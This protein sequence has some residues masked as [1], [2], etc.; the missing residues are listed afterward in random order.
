MGNKVE[1]VFY[2]LFHLNIPQDKILLEKYLTE[3]SPDS[4]K[5]ERAQLFY[6]ALKEKISPKEDITFEIKKL[7]KQEF[8]NEITYSLLSALYK[9]RDIESAKIKEEVFSNSSIENQEEICLYIYQ[10]EQAFIQKTEDEF[11]EIAGLRYYAEPSFS[12]KG[13]IKM[14]FFKKEDISYLNK[15]EKLLLLKNCQED[16]EF[17]QLGIKRKT[18]LKYHPNISIGG[19]YEG[20]FVG[21]SIG[22]NEGEKKDI[23]EM[24]S[25]WHI[26]L[27]D[28]NVNISKIKES[29]SPVDY[30]RSC[31]L[32][33]KDLNKKYK[34]FPVQ[35]K[36]KEEIKNQQ[37]FRHSI[38]S[39]G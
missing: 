12:L 18:A 32:F 39:L 22:N 8:G 20:Y 14:G 5:P 4:K 1:D 28:K 37:S 9:S 25:K 33:K 23:K 7:L 24:L 11:N 3:L 10:K 19:N 29:T 13:F 38:Y 31:G 16:V 17:F 30:I 6:N 35:E 15:S 27:V 26:F 21:D 34:I 2:E 36:P